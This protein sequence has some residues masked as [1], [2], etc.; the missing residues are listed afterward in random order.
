[1]QS[2]LTTQFDLE[3]GFIDTFL[4][5]FESLTTAMPTIVADDVNNLSYTNNNNDHFLHNYNNNTENCY[6]NDF[7]WPLLE[8]INSTPTTSLQPGRVTNNN[9]TITTNDNTNNNATATALVIKDTCKKKRRLDALCTHLPLNRPL[10]PLIAS[11]NPQKNDVV[12]LLNSSNNNNSDCNSNKLQTLSFVQFSPATTKK[13]NK[14]TSNNRKTNG[15]RNK[16][17]TTPVATSPTQQFQQPITTTPSNNSSSNNSSGVSCP[18]NDN[19]SNNGCI[20]LTIPTINYNNVVNNNNNNNTDNNSIIEGNNI[21]TTTMSN[22]RESLKRL[23][24]ELCTTELKLDMQDFMQ[25]LFKEGYELVVPIH[26]EIHLSVTSKGCKRIK[27]NQLSN[28]I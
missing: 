26:K 10:S 20:Q 28:I 9:N 15:S 13:R 17:P 24:I 14:K 25:S 1:M 16:S 6:L 5:P 4:S 7:S 2:A 22:K 3:E 27:P 23:N 11:N 18:I 21:S 19:K 8:N 12:A